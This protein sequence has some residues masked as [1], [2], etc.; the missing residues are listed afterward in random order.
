MTYDTQSGA[1]HYGMSGTSGTFNLTSYMSGN[2]TVNCYDQAAGVTVC[3]RLLGILSEYIFMQPFGYILATDLVGIGQCNNP[4]YPNCAAP[5]NIALLG[6]G[7]VTDLVSPN[8]TAFGNHAFV[9][10]NSKI[11][12]ACAGP[13]VGTETLIQYATAAID[14]SNPGERSV[15][16]DTNLDGVFS[17]IEVDCAVTV[18]DVTGIK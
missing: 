2:G 3:S 4:F 13:H 7:G 10:L 15:S 6:T 1:P 9:R 12:D 14:I 8:R 5:Y 11:Y 16:P 18:G 17:E